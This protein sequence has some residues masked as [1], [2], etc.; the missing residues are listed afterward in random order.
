MAGSSIG[1]IFRVTTWGESHGKALGAVIDGVPAG[2]P[3]NESDIQ[4]YMDRRAPGRSGASTSR[5]EADQVE[6]LS[7]V[8]EGL[9]TGSPISIMVRNTSQH[10]SDYDAISQIYRPGHADYTFD[11]KFGF[12][13]YR[14]GGRSS[15]RETLSRVAAGA[16]AAKI[17]GRLGMD[18]CSYALSI[19]PVTIDKGR[20]DRSLISSSATCMPD[21][22]ADERAME[23]VNEMRD[24]TDSVGGIIETVITGMPA[25]IGSPVF[26]KLSADLAKA[27]MSIGACKAVEFGD[28][29]RAAAATGSE[30]N[31]GF[32]M[33]D[34]RVV[35]ETNHS[36]G[37]LGGMSDGD[38]LIMRNYF[39]P[40]PSIYKSQHTVTRDGR[41]ADV[42]VAGRH[43]PVIVPRAVVVV[44][45]MC[46]ITILDALL[47]NMGSRISYLEEFYDRN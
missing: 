10:S 13:D 29:I 18:V 22:E 39:K 1:N 16:I 35:K 20:F 3:L 5:K 2:L 12:R 32:R 46:A 9:T 44:E 23:Y 27:T 11:A 45:S 25:G 26:D 19:G 17:L 38:E 40:T 21:A 4:P 8:F 24:K 37:L 14:G 6:I 34:G 43:D 33:S 28:G 47:A 42:K 31:D 41:D 36:G 30:N 15:G 7:G